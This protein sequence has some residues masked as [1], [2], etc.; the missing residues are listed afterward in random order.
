MLDFP[1]SYPG[2]EKS[3]GGN[4]GE[5]GRETRKTPALRRIIFGLRSPDGRQK[6]KTDPGVCWIAWPF[7]SSFYGLLIRRSLVRVQQGEP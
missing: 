5:P 2:A 3:P 1:G 4:G 6:R 7:W